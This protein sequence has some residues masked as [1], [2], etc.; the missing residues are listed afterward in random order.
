MKYTDGTEIRLGDRV[1]IYNTEEGVIVASIDTDEYSDEFPKDVWSCLESGVMVKFTNGAL[2]HLE[3]S[4]P[5][6]PD[7]IVRLS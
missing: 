3:D 4:N 1:M 5:E 2:L 6:E 7:E